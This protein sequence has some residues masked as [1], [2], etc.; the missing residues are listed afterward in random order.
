MNVVQNAIANQ[1]PQRNKTRQ[2]IRFA[3]TTLDDNKSI[4]R[5]GKRVHFVVDE[6]EQI[7]PTV[8]EY[9]SFPDGCFTVAEQLQ[10]S[11]TAKLEGR[12]F[13]RI[14]RKTVANLERCHQE[15]RDLPW[16]TETIDKSFYQ[17]WAESDARGLERRVSKA[18]VFYTERAK[19][20]LTVLKE[21]E[22]LVWAIGK[23]KR[24]E[25]LRQHSLEAT[26]R[27]RIFAH[28]LAL[29]DAEVV[30]YFLSKTSIEQVYDLSQKRDR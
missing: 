18:Q 11:M 16:D 29:G 10:F 20:V 12:N 14:H 22:N 19:V 2:R 25:I 1:L 23:Q 21:Q 9:E 7:V 15:C 17:H 5:A 8:H 24:A 6:N 4:R 28:L 30:R 13:Y 26:R 27:S 3:K